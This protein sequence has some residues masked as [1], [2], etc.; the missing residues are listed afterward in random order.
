MD[1]LDPSG[2]IVKALP[3]SSATS[4]LLNEIFPF[5]T[6]VAPAGASAAGIPKTKAETVTIMQMRRDL[7]RSR[8][9]RSIVI[10][11]PAR[12][13]HVPADTRSLSGD[14]PHGSMRFMELGGKGLRT[15]SGSG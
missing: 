6:L 1:S 11:S 9:T 3:T 8:A 7:R 2:S 5:V 14:R 12:A 10:P 4:I 15:A 13:P